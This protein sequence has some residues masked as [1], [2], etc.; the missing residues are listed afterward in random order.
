MMS[1]PIESSEGMGVAPKITYLTWDKP[2]LTS[3]TEWLL[4]DESSDSAD[5]SATLLLLPTQQAGR[6]LREALATEMARRGGGLF[7]P[8]TALPAVMLAG[9]ESGE[10]IADTVACLW[11]WVN[12]LQGE[13]IGR[14]AALFPRL[15]SVVD[16]NWCRLMARS[17]HELRGALVDAGWDCAAVARSEHCEKESQRWKDLAKLESVYRKSLA[18]A[19]LCDV[20]D[21]RRAVAAK[22]VLP[23]G[24]C[25]VVLL[26]VTDLVPLVQSA[27]GQAAVQGAAIESVVFGP[28]GGES[29]FDDWGRPVPEQWCGRELSLA[30]ERLHPSLDERTQARDVANWLKRYGKNVY[31]TVGAG[32]ADPGVVPH[33]ERELGN[34]G[35]RHFNPAGRQCRFT[36]VYAFIKSLF[37]VLQHPSFNN[38]DAFLRLPD[39]WDWLAAQ[40]E[41][42]EPTQLLA[43]LDELRGEHLPADL[44]AAAALDFVKRSETENIS[45]R[46]T[47]RSALRLLQSA[48][49]ALSKNPPSVGLAG[50][51]KT[52]FAQRQFDSA[53]PADA[54]NIEL[55]RQLN[56]RLARLDAAVP[57]RA[58]RNPV[59]ELALVLEDLGR[60]SVILERPSDTVDLQGWLE[61]AWEDAPHLLVTGANEGHLPASIHGDRFLPESIRAGLGLR[62][63]G[64]RLARDAWLLELLLNSRARKG[65]VDL[66]VG[67][68]RINGDPLKPSRLL[69]RCPDEQLPARV[70]H[71]FEKLPTDEQPPSWSAPWKL[72]TGEVKPVETLGVTSIASYLDCSYRFY[73]RHVL[74]MEALDLE[75]RELD[76]RGFGSLVHHVLDAYGRNVSA[77]GTEDA[78]LIQQYFIAE[79]GRQVEQQFGKRLSLPLTVQREIARKR[80]MLVALE[81]SKARREGWAIIDT[82]RP[83]EVT[84]DRLLISGRI[85]RI[86]KNANT[87]EVRVLDY[88]TSNKAK[89]PA[90]AHWRRF[91][92]ARDGEIVP[93]YA[94]FQIGD[95]MYRWKNL[96]L[97]LYAWALE[98]EFGT[99]IALGYFNIPEVGAN[100]GISLL[101]PYDRELSNSAMVCAKGVVADVKAGRFWPPFS[102]PKYDDFKGI[103]FGQATK[104]AI[105]PGK[106]G[107][108]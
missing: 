104:T 17:L 45:R 54:M 107:A 53:D 34:V 59:A 76:A 100:T 75:Q 52:T 29:L 92:E 30:N 18:K 16:F 102:K 64:D 19:G 89:P 42:I 84:L 6:R 65:R 28:E 12:V 1:S 26:G 66:F 25:R 38:A 98:Q 86:E 58:K 106:E 27:L 93:G 97:P 44:A 83:F 74:R 32:A 46:I 88:K 43:G 91:N 15:P 61:L 33:L 23:E 95:K 3:A 94:R 41:T 108:A 22:P 13:S 103:L 51:L 39:S 31:Q 77:R 36:A 21:A 96:Q 79:L 9:G 50:F 99:A 71:L 60:E 35:I 55:L 7:P 10:P 37:A 4:A 8:Q 73:L 101:E 80:L 69:F 56:E 67:R 14:C 72:T 62:T 81:Q 5:L 85:D 63:N 47:A 40:D 49:A 70:V 78:K 20:H 87:G 90:G 68:Q 105:E 57:A 48:L 24:I 2:L 11:H 82:E